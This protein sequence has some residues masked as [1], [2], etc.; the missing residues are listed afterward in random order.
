[1]AKM[2]TSYELIRQLRDVDPINEPN[3]TREICNEAADEISRLYVDLQ[4]QHDRDMTLRAE[5]V[6]RLMADRDSER[7]ARIKLDAA[8]REKDKAMD[9]LFERLSA[10][11]VDCSDLFS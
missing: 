7:E 1:M 6:E 3:T 2:R 10:A 4:A 8:L 11:G 5:Q 9:I